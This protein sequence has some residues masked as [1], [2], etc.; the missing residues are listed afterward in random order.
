[1]AWKSRQIGTTHKPDCSRVF[2]RY[3]LTCP[4]CQELS[5]G[6]QPRQ[7]WG[8]R[9]RA[10]YERFVKDLKAHDCRKSQCG[11]VCTAFDW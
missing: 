9:K 1:M 11:P 5:Q 3:D 2:K 10:G 4:R 8:D 7:R 6:A